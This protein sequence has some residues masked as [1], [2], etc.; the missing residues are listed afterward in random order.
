MAP[1]FI[2]GSVCML[3]SNTDPTITLSHVVPGRTSG[4]ADHYALNDE[5]ALMLARRIVTTFN[6]TKRPSVTMRPVE[7][8]LYSADDLG[9]IVGDNLRKT[10]DARQVIARLVDG[11]RFSEFKEL[12]GTTLVTG[13]KLVVVVMR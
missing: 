7:E 1:I 13:R 3:S 4:V 8:P 9:G 5:H 12:Y 6:S 11:S 2:V 10:Y